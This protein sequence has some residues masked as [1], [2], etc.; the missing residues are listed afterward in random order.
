M[1][2]FDRFSGYKDGFGL[3]KDFNINDTLASYYGSKR[4]VK[5]IYREINSVTKKK[6]KET[7]DINDQILQK[8]ARKNKDDVQA[9]LMKKYLKLSQDDLNKEA[10]EKDQIEK[11]VMEDEVDETLDGVDKKTKEQVK[12]DLE[13][14][15]KEDKQ[16]GK[17]PDN[18]D[19]KKELQSRIYEATYNRMYKDYAQKVMNIKNSQYDDMAIAIGT[20]EAIEIIAM[21]KNLEK[22]DLLY[23][24]H[25]NKNINE[26]KKIK[27]N[28]QE[29]KSK[30]DYNQKGIEN[31]TN[32]R[33]RKINQLYAIREEQYIKYIKA[34]KDQTKTLQEKAL[35]KREY[36]KANLNLIQNIPSLNEYTEGL[37]IQGDNERLAKEAKVEE[38][39]AI[40][41]S[42][43][44][45]SQKVEKV[46]DS[47]MADMV[48]DVK[49]TEKQR[50]INSFEISRNQQ[51]DAL[52]KG[53]YGAAKGIVDA[54]RDKRIYDENIEKTPDQSTVLETKKEVK[55]E[56]I[57]SD[58]N[59]LASLR[60]VNNIEEKTPEE[61]E[62][63][64]NDRDQDIE[65]KIKE[66]AYK[67]QIEQETE[68]ERYRRQN[69]KPNG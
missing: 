56:E 3:N 50:D 68:Y 28:K 43:N 52:E 13:Q 37:E 5:E 42:F 54:Q 32:D 40:N 48:Y 10:I 19:K 34:L 44:N 61:L 6:F 23:H 27:D 4:N 7:L 1:G 45:K 47:K 41:N 69:K 33:A 51:K 14:E 24:N 11:K 65:D 55:K 59:F 12:K 25:T 63:M 31:N 66:N 21:E 39:S 9:E 35:F 62:S 46:T 8:Y 29:F 26:V 2:V 36:E 18:K 15:Q 22:I 20:K 58:S 17:V 67:E 16:K 53:N 60:K 64:I 49:Q 38:E 30:F 57:Q